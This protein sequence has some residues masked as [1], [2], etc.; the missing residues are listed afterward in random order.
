MDKTSVTGAF[1]QQQGE[2]LRRLRLTPE[3]AGELAEEV[4]RL[5]DAV[6]DAARRLDFNDDPGRFTALLAAAAETKA[7]R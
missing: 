2:E 6:I 4:A 3:R 5:N 7:G 1:I